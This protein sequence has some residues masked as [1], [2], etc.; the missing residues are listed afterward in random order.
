MVTD[1]TSVAY[2]RRKWL[3]KTHTEDVEAIGCT[4]R[5]KFIWP[6]GV[7][8][9]EISGISLYDRDTLWPKFVF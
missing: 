9:L 7:Y 3:N 8:A 6:L 5:T 1:F 2:I 4:I